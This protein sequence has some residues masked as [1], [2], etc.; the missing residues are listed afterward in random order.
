[1]PTT[2]ATE[3]D[4][5][6]DRTQQ[7]AQYI[8]AAATSAGY[9]IDSPRGGGK[10]ALAK[11]TGMSQTSVGRMLAGQT[12]PDPNVLERLAEAV[13]VPLPELLV[14]SGVISRKSSAVIAADV[15]PPD[16]SPMPASAAAQ[17]LGIRDPEN[18]A[19]FERTVQMLLER[20]RG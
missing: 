14:R 4:L 3:S 2:H 1:M 15:R 9:D 5:Q 16:R 18:V 7:F 6:R 12:L 11:A 20:E 19:F 8:R 13:R 10:K 17:A